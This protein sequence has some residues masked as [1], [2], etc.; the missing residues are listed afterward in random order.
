[1]QKFAGLR[2]LFGYMAAH[3]GKKLTFMGGEFGQFIEWK[4]DDKLDWFLLD[5]EMHRK[6]QIYVKALNHFYLEHTCLWE[7]DNGW[8]GF[9]WIAPDDYNNSVIAF[10]RKG[11]SPKDEMVAV[12]NFTPINRPGYR[13]GVPKAKSY[14]EVFNSDHI[15]FGGTGT[16][17][18]DIIMVEKVTCHQYGQSITI[19]LPPMSAVFYQSTR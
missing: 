4:Y 5:Y 17:K 15:S 16:M 2:T 7:D 13:I 6:M 9:E 11:R 14:K 19:S 8:S 3:P 1:N 18:E 12:F 10:L